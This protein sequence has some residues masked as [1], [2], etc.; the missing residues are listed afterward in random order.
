MHDYFF[1]F[2]NNKNNNNNHAHHDN[3]V[4]GALYDGDAVPLGPPKKT[5]NSHKNL[6]SVFKIQLPI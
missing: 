5:K 1:F 2:Y 6:E 4:V 3:D